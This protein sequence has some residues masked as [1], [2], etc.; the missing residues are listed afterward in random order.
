MPDVPEDRFT[1]AG[2]AAEL[3]RQLQRLAAMESRDLT[4]SYEVTV[5]ATRADGDEFTVI[6][7]Q[8]CSPQLLGR[9][10]NAADYSALFTPTQTPWQLACILHQ[11]MSEPTER[12]R[13]GPAEW[14]ADLVP[15]PSEIRWF[16]T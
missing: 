12:G 4:F 5:V 16:P 10:A 14:A 1:E 3:M 9:R 8:A 7:R 13:T 2:Q 11:H 6:Y 15:D